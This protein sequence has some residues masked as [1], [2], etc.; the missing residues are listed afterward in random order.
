MCAVER[1]PLSRSPVATLGLAAGQC[2]IRQ[3]TCIG[4]REEETCRKSAIGTCQAGWPRM[5]PWWRWAWFIFAEKG[6]SLPILQTFLYV[7]SS[8]RGVVAVSPTWRFDHSPE[9][10]LRWCKHRI[11]AVSLSSRKD[12]QR[13]SWRRKQ[14][15][16]LNGEGIDIKNYHIAA[17]W[18]KNKA[19]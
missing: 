6:A 15:K 10:A 19:T 1:R 16:G 7:S 18:Y 14:G 9:A 13:C 8:K 5:A 17:I 12:H 3:Y 11:S 4:A 2:N